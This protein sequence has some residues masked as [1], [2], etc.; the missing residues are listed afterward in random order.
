MDTPKPNFALSELVS[1]ETRVYLEGL[2]EDA[3]MLMA[4]DA[5]KEEMIKEL[6]ARLDNYLTT[7]IID[8]FPPEHLDEFIRLNEEKKPKE[9]IENF[10]KEKIPNYKNIFAHAFADFRDL[11]LGKVTAVRNVPDREESINKTN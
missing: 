4:D 10:L 11:Y 6:Y 7:V 5:L 9:E 1:Q 3:G 2:L 8:H